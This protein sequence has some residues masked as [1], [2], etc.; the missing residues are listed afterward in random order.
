[1][2]RRRCYGSVVVTDNQIAKYL[3]MIVKD[4]IAAKANP[5]AAQVHINAIKARAEHIVETMKKERPDVT[6]APV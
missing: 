6:G 4:C 2:D 5:T 3:E 1:M